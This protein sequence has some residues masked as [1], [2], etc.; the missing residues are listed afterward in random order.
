VSENGTICVWD[1]TNGKCLARNE[2]LF[3]GEG[4]RPNILIS[5]PDKRHVAVAGQASDIK[6]VDTWR[7]E[8]RQHH[9]NLCNR[10]SDGLPLL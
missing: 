2:T 1:Y 6:I 5:L 3:V 4:G 7:L 10:F 9:L 8:V